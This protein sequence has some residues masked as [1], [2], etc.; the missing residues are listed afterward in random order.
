MYVLNINIQPVV[1]SALATMWPSL[2]LHMAENVLLI[3]DVD[4]AL[5]AMTSVGREVAGEAAQVVRSVVLTQAARRGWQVLPHHTYASWA[6]STV[7]A[8]DREWLILDPFF[9]TDSLARKATRITLT[10]PADAQLPIRGSLTDFDVLEAGQCWG[11]V[12]DA[13]SS[14]RTL[15]SVSR[16]CAE[17]GSCVGHVVIGAASRFGR[18]MVDARV[19]RVRWSVYLAGDWQTLHLRDGCPYLPR[20]GR[21]LRSAIVSA[22]GQASVDLR[23]PSW[24][25]LGS[26]WQVLWL[27]RAVQNT[28]KSECLRILDTVAQR[29][30]CAPRIRDLRILGDD[31]PCLADND[32][33]YL[34]D[35]PLRD[36]LPQ[37]LS[38]WSP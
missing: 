2:G 13:V 5:S 4:P 3:D 34:I 37:S 38:A 10:R 19:K 12:D 22:D 11:I 31:V 18:A 36:L 25:A 33:D 35:T 21:L 8:D 20:S 27:D 14:G 6:R 9:E 26:I 29:I 15:Y 32:G 30:G 16:L 17:R 24:R 28:I 23:L 1:V 7:G